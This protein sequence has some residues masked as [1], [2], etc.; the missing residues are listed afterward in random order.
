MS[1]TH[2]GDAVAHGQRF[3]LIVGHENERDAALALD[4]LE[5]KLH[6]AAKL[7]IQRTQRFVQQQDIRL[8]DERAGNG[9][10]LLLSAGKAGDAAL[11]KACQTD[12]RQH[13]ADFFCGLF[14]V[15][16]AQVGTEGDVLRDIQ[17]RK[18]RITLKDRVDGTLIR[19]QGDDVLPLVEDFAAGRLL[20][21]ADAAQKRRFA[22][23]GRTQQRHKLVFSD[24]DAHAAQRGKAILKDHAKIPDGKNRAIIHEMSSSK[25]RRSADPKHRRRGLARV[26]QI[27]L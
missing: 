6:L 27:V 24:V 5:F 25:I 21:A 4:A 22:A 16:L 11:F 15:L 20:K 7:Q 23:A 8:V 12:Q 26:F 18:E 3:F 19:R 2:H 1:G 17:M 13:A 10:A 14:L 9:D